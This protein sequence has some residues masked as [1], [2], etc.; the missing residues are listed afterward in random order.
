MVELLDSE[1]L[2]L[3]GLT[4][5][6]T[7]LDGGA[8]KGT[9]AE[10]EF[11][12]KVV[13]LLRAGNTARVILSRHPER[14]PRLLE[15]GESIGDVPALRESIPAMIDPR[16]GVRSEASENLA[17]L[18]RDIR[19]LQSALRSRATSILHRPNL[20]K[21][22]Q[23]EGLTVKNDRY[24]LP[25]KAEYRSWMTGPV[26]DRSQSGSTLYIEPE[27]IVQEGDRLLSM[28]DRERDEVLRILWELTREVREHRA[29]L[30]DV[31]EKL[32]QVDF[33]FAKASFQR[34][35]G[36]STPDLSN[37]GVL[38]LHDA[39]HPYLM[40][41][42]RDTRSDHRKPDLES[43][44][45]QVVP[46]DVRLGTPARI[47]V[48]TGPNTGGKTVAMK[49]IGLNVLLALSGVPIAA[50]PGGK[51]PGY[52]D[53]FVDIGDE[54]SLEQNLSTFS[55]HVRQ[56]VQV[57]RHSSE[58]S[59]ILLDELG[60]GTDPLEGAA[61]GTALLDHFRESGWNAIITTHLG[62][63]KEYA[64]L[65]EC[66]ENAAMEFDPRSLRPTYRLL[67]GVPG[68]SNALAI[69]RRLGVKEEVVVAAEGQI[70]ESEGPTREII[71][72]MEKSKRRVEKERRRAERMRK[73]VQG[74]KR[75]YEERLQEIETRRE[76]LDREGEAEVDRTVRSARE[77]LL[78]LVDKLKNVPQT[79]KAIVDELAMAVELLLVSTPLGEK[80]EEFARSLRKEDEVYVPKFRA[81]GKVRK[82]N[83]GERLVTV[84]LGGIPT[85][86]SFD[87][88]SWVEGPTE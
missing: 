78:P 12:W 71:S 76:S 27:E 85:Q 62:S 17:S 59:L 49:T 46:L 60:S 32:A 8:S 74:D 70:A 5:I 43:I 26:R 35:Y 44:H 72:R 22:F 64:Y 21:C 79:H 51:V 23:T 53:L 86:V 55:S 56:I 82:I 1:R 65:H 40:W 31:Q 7:A 81:K 75:E 2:A 24:L 38:E 73:R 87:D 36:L 83:K 16:E 39:R 84:L 80:R 41:L 18:R 9:P 63:L 28:L 47:L 11:L 14:M 15:L 48:V 61:L 33:A 69:A 4:D 57:L 13:E 19:E 37:D 66:V 34:A 10:P 52:N 45:R 3:G 67:M 58:R 77:R 42:A 68:S 30:R 6:T 54:Q 29:V 88:V 20:R 25:V 50:A